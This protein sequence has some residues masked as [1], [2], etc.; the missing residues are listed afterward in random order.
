MEQVDQA[1]IIQE[2][3]IINQFIM[4]ISISLQQQRRFRIRELQL[5]VSLSLTEMLILLDI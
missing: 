2:R 5:K 4:K 3:T 1:L